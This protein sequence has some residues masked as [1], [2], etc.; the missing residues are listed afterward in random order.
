MRE[1]FYAGCV[2]L[3]KIVVVAV[4]TLILLVTDIIRLFCM[5]IRYAYYEERSAR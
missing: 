1:F 4:M 5:L 3:K 2:G